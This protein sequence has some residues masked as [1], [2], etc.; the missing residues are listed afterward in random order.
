M[1]V[2]ALPLAASAR[3]TASVGVP[4]STVQSSCRST[5]ASRSAKLG[6]ALDQERLW[7]QRRCAQAPPTQKATVEDEGLGRDHLCCC[8]D[9]PACR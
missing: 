9:L 7:S 5:A 3:R 6:H 8:E 2:L 1:M 4:R